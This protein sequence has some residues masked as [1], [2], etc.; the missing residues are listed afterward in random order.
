MSQHSPATPDREPALELINTEI[1]ASLDRQADASQ[2]IDNKAVLLVGY[3]G[4]AAAFLATRHSQHVLGALAF[5]GYAISAAT[6]TLAYAV[7]TRQDVPTPRR[8]FTAYHDKPEAD[9]LTALAA[10]RVQAF[11]KNARKHHRKVLLWWLSLA[12]LASGMIL[13]I[14]ALTSAYW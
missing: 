3:A 9:I 14:A 4:A 8:L 7:R 12:S 1:T 6:G 2:N 11:E 10:T 5:A 13:M